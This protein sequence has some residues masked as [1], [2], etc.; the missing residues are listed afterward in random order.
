ESHIN[1]IFTSFIWSAFLHFLFVILCHLFE[2]YR[3]HEPLRNVCSEF[4]E[5][6]LW[7]A[8]VGFHNGYVL[9]LA[10]VRDPS[11]GFVIGICLGFNYHF[12]LTIDHMI[13]QKHVNAFEEII[14]VAT[15]AIINAVTIYIAVRYPFGIT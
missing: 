15:I 11:I 9:G 5:I 7:H 8:Y 12:M 13:K 3:M 4:I 6:S 14:F 2:C 10:N 1:Y